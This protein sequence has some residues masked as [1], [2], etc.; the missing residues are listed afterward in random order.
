M[1]AYQQTHRSTTNLI[2]R[3]GVPND[4]DG[5]DRRNGD[6]VHPAV[7]R[8]IEI[9]RPELEAAASVTEINQALRGQFIDTQW[10]PRDFT[11]YLDERKGA[12]RSNSCSE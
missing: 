3:F 4:Y 6:V 1:Q 7:R 10:L 5:G 9:I 2:Y 12:V 11:T 8:W